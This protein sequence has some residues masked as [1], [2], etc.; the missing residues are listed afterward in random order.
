MNEILNTQTSKLQLDKWMKEMIQVEEHL[1]KI[2]LHYHKYFISCS[3]CKWKVSY[4]ESSEYFIINNNI[5]C[6]NCK[7]GRITLKYSSM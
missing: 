7:E 1:R 6:H 4:S 2:S 5:S 3:S